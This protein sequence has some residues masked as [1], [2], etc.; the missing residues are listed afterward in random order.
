MGRSDDRGDIAKAIRVARATEAQDDR[1]G[2]GQMRVSEG[3][4]VW[5]A[6]S[7]ECGRSD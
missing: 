7:E 2:I 6:S 5:A 3:T 1:P 4:Q